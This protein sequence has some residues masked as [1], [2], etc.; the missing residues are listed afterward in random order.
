MSHALW[1]AREGPD[2]CRESSELMGLGR[3]YERAGDTDRAIESFQRASAG[4]DR[5]VRPHALARLATLLGRMSRYDEAATAWQSVLDLNDLRGRRHGPLSTLTR[6][7]AEALAIHHE[8]RA[9]DL[10]AA[11]QY[12]QHLEA[13]ADDRTKREAAHRL[14]RINQKLNRKLIGKGTLLS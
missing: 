8:H 1:L 7:A 12:A 10:D 5:D 11:K 4:D 3:L 6:R 14:G 2:A 9:R 13:H